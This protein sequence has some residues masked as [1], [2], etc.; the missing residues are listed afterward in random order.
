MGRMKDIYIDMINEGWGG[1]PNQYLERRL[2]EMEI[3]K[4]EILCPN[5][6]VDNLI[7]E[8]A[9]DLSC[10]ECGYEFTLV[11]NTSVRFK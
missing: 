8:N 7:Q 10:T 6:T 5:C 1:D 9:K 3:S 4:S 11:N 2:R